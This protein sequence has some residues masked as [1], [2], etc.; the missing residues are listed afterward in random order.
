MSIR[1]NALFLAVAAAASV[2]AVT[3]A[4]AP[5]VV[6]M[7]SLWLVLLF[8]AGGVSHELRHP[9]NCQLIAQ[10]QPAST[11]KRSRA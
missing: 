2:A 5:R 9:T 6:P 4:A 11:A 7:K 3:F 8:L 10:R 1:S